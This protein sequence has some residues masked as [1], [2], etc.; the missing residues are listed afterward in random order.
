[1]S[2]VTKSGILFSLKKVEDPD[3][4]KDHLLLNSI[5]N[6]VVNKNTITVNFVLPIPL[7]KLT[8]SLKKKFS[9][10]I[11]KDFPAYKNIDLDI[12]TYKTSINHTCSLDFK[13]PS[14]LL[15]F[16]T[17]KHIIFIIIRYLFIKSLRM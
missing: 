12:F 14:N 13:L 4:N 3:F 11:K 7:S 17:R 10:A 1:M 2:D 8:D 15:V 16:K 5:K 9:D 6:V